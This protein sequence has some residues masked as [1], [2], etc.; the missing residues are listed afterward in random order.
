MPIKKA[1]LKAVRKSARKQLRNVRITSE[2]RTLAK[3]FEQFLSQSQPA[4]AKQQLAELVRRIDQAQAKGILHANAAA[5]RKSRFTRR[6]AKL[7]A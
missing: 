1:A 4:Q 2:L 3:K 7:P 5:R 6:L